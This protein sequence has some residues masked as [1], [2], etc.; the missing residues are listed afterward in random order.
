MRSWI[1]LMKHGTISAFIPNLVQIIKIQNTRPFILHD[2]YKKCQCNSD[3]RTQWL[4]DIDLG[5]LIYPVSAQEGVKFSKMH[6]APP[7]VTTYT[8]EYN[9][10]RMGQKYKARGRLYVKKDSFVS[11]WYVDFVTFVLLHA[12]RIPCRYTWRFAKHVHLY[13]V[14]VWLSLRS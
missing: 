4:N 2:Q 11:D 13:G 7:R 6:T 10:D 5:I 14:Y 1:Y 9:V 3:T 12:T 8:L